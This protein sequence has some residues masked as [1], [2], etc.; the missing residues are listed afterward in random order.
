MRRTHEDYA[1]VESIHID[2][3]HGDRSFSFDLLQRPI[4]LGSAGPI[5][6]HWMD[7]RLLR[8]KHPGP[9]FRSCVDLWW[10]NAEMAGDAVLLESQ[11]HIVLA[12][13]FPLVNTAR[14]LQ[15]IYLDAHLHPL[16]DREVETAPDGRPLGPSQRTY[17]LPAEESDRL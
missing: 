2:L 15:D 14:S 12:E 6:Y 4:E 7:S 8:R 5:R 1:M 9:N 16:A 13:C 11:F 3:K 17:T 10:A